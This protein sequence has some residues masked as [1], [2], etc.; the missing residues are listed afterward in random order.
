MG[1]GRGVRA[2]DRDDPLPLWAQL[3]R[4]LT[5]RLGAGAFD[6]AFPGEVELQRTYQVSRHT[7]REALRRLREAGLLDTARGRSTRVRT[8][9]IEQ[10]LG[11]MYS[12]FRQ[13]EAQG[14]HQRSD[15]LAQDL[16]T[17][18][19]AATA[20]GLAPDA[21][22]FHLERVRFAGGLP[23][24]HDRL[25]LP[26]ELG[27]PLLRTDF[28]HAALYDELATISGVRLTGG[29]ERISAV[30][31]NPRERALLSVPRGVACLSVVRTA[32]RGGGPL[33]YRHSLVRGDRYALLTSWSPAGY[34]VGADPA[35]VGAS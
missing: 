14:L 35:E 24:A 5:R 23:L 32:D 1:A 34:R 17:D 11:S 4:E 22:L 28:S 30:V 6:A 10:P 3:Q 18:E 7:V 33:E 27:R 26:A 2:L 15:V 12:L 29:R 13:V 16:R 19:V 31:P 21:Q 25:W 9:A 20:L 8:P